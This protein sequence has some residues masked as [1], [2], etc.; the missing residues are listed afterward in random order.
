[1]L[2]TKTSAATTADSSIAPQAARGSNGP[3]A[4]RAA[5][6]Q[7]RATMPNSGAAL[8]LVAIAAPSATPMG[9]ADQTPPSWARR[10]AAM[11]TAR[12][13]KVSSVSTV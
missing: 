6:S 8:T 9:S 7:L 4:R 11:S 3:S 5:R 1:M 12:A 13:K 10:T 2:S